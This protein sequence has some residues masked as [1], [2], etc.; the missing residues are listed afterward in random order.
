MTAVCSCNLNGKDILLES[1]QAPNFMTHGPT[2]LN[3]VI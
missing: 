3:D 1:Q 2:E